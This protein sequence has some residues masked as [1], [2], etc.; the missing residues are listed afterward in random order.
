MNQFKKTTKKR[1]KRRG[2]YFQLG[3]IIAGGLTLVAFEWTTPVYLTDLPKPFETYEAE[4]DIPVIIPEVEIEKPKVKHIK[5]PKKSEIIMIVEKLIEPIPDPDPTPDPEP[6][7]D[8]GEFKID[9]EFV[10]API[11]VPDVN[12]EFIGGMESMF[13]YLG[14]NIKYPKQE[15]IA[16][17]QGTVHLQFVVGKKGEIRDIKVLRGVNDAIDK[18]AIRVLRAMPKWKPGKQHGKAVSVRY[19]LPIKF[20]LN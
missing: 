15:K 10:E 3:F 11:L 14:E 6:V 20:M 8:P 16:G 18:E 5:A 7:F 9:E 1:E 2:I 12:P 13:K 17:I 4:W 19:M